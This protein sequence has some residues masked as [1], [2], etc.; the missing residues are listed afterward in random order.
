MSSWIWQIGPQD[1]SSEIL[2][3]SSGTPTLAKSD[4]VYV[5]NKGA[6]HR[7]RSTE[8]EAAA[9]FNSSTTISKLGV[10]C[11][12]VTGT[13]TV[14][15]RKNSAAGSQSISVTT[16]GLKE[17]TTNSDSLAST[18]TFDVQLS[19]SSGH[20]DVCSI[21]QVN[22]LVNDNGNARSRC[23]VGLT[24]GRLATSAQYLPVEGYAN[25]SVTTEAYHQRKVYSSQT[26]S[27]LRV[28]VNTAPASSTTVQFR[29]NGSAGSQSVSFS[30]T[31]AFQDTSGSDSV[32]SGDLVCL[33]K[34]SG[35]GTDPVLIFASMVID[36]STIETQTARGYTATS[37]PGN[38]APLSG[39][40]NQAAASM[41]EA[42]IQCR[43]NVADKLSNLRVYVPTNTRN[44][45][46]TVY[47]RQNATNTSVTVSIG[48]STTGAFEDT[49]NSYTTGTSDLLSYGITTGGS[50]GVLE[51]TSIQLTQGVGNIT[52]TLGT[53]TAS[54]AVVVPAINPSGTGPTLTVPTSTASAAVVVPSV[55]EGSV[56]LT[57]PVDTASAATIVPTVT[58]G[59]VTVTQG[60]ATSQADAISPAVTAGSITLTLGTATATTSVV[61]PTVSSVL[62]LTLP[63][64]TAQADAIVPTVSASSVTLTV[65]TSTASAAVVVPTV[66][67]S[68]VTLT[69][70]TDTASADVIVP[71]ISGSVTLTVPTST[72]SAD[73]VVPSIS[74]VSVTLTLPVSTASAATVLPVV[75]PGSV[76]ITKPVVSATTSITALNVLVGSVTLSPGTATASAAGIPFGVS[77]GSVT[78]TQGVVTA[79]TAVVVPLISGPL[80]MGI[81]SAQADAIVMGVTGGGT[82]SQQ[83]FF[84]APFF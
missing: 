31:G 63:T 7:V 78:L 80:L 53:A 35:S 77:A 73:A 70:P 42:N 14:T 55:T 62:T 37:T 75:V 46:S 10:Y 28:Y 23:T 36:G 29:K 72:A 30:S 32:S 66:S 45:S 47:L 26:F 44:G 51:L 5:W 21:T 6:C 57:V 71:G 81:V 49:T 38:Y 19:M 4:V 58:A 54:G 74:A 52:L 34:V 13:A 43:A 24:T 33:E 3:G 56:T 76:T 79:D 20:S 50:T 11:S 69:V 1:P 2:D 40:I 15:S 64:A 60:T 84:F 18:D 41:T 61:V 39:S 8:S 83:S 16:T 27:K 22:C 67:A 82:Q 12:S 59:S 68:S 48:S 25:A 9:V 17:D 65:P